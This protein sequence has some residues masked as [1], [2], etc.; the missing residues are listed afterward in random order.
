MAIA[1][2]CAICKQYVYLNDQWGCVNGHP[3]TEISQWYDPD[4]GQPITPYWLSSTTEPEQETGVEEA[5]PP[6]PSE[7]PAATAE[8][9]PVTP[10]APLD[11]LALLSRIVSALAPYPGYRVQYGTD[12]DI[13]IDNEVANASWPGG[14]KRI[15]YEA[16]LKAVEDERTVYL[17]EAIKESGSGLS[18]GTVGAES[19]TT[20]G[21]TRWGK[22]REVIAG[23]EGVEMDASWDYAATRRIIESAVTESGWR[24]KVVLRKRS[25]QW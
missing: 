13:V 4:T 3:W 9:A 12:T 19:Y 24:M 16:I 25:A 17:W 8:T 1:G 5:D 23:P 20:V 15:H 11:R 18:F 22:R 10:S 2:Y 21:T 14:K 6:S 7:P